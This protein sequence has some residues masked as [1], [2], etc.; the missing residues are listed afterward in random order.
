MTKSELLEE[1]RSQVNE[2]ITNARAAESRATELLALEIDDLD[3]DKQ[4]P[5][6]I[7]DLRQI[8]Q[9]IEAA[10]DSCQDCWTSFIDANND[11]YD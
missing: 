9:E 11:E 3:P 5:D 2:V 7:E 8:G 1:I 10:G 4:Q 6:A